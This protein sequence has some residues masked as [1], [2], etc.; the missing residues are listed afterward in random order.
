MAAT[1][2]HLHTTTAHTHLD[3]PSILLCDKLA[4]RG[5]HKEVHVGPQTSEILQLGILEF[6]LVFLMESQSRA[7]FFF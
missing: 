5:G 3:R 4:A 1:L 6:I 2:G 7:S